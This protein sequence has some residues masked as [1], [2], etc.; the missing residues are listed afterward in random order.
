MPGNRKH[1]R[2]LN[3]D[4][5]ENTLQEVDMLWLETPLSSH[6]TKVLTEEALVGRER[7]TGTG[8]QPIEFHCYGNSISRE[9]IMDKSVYQARWLLGSL[10]VLCLGIATMGIA[11]G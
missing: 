9:A 11:L 2:A 8:I 7:K 6:R 10:L 3:A 1:I 4:L 5:I